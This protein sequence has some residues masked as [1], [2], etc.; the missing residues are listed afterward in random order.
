MPK[1]YIKIP[2]SVRFVDAKTR[3]PFGKTPDEI[4]KNTVSFED[5]VLKVMDNPKWNKSY[6]A[7]KSADAI[8]MALREALDGDGVMV[9]ADSDY[10]EMKTAVESPEIIVYGPTGE[11]RVSP[12][13]GIHPRLS[14]Q[15][16]PLCDAIINASEED[17]RAEKDAPADEAKP[18]A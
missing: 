16:I 4:A 7:I 11:P 1:I 14:P 2:E 12:G 18:E 5:L 13:F 17:P 6:K 15:L 3:E 10:Q 8:M 9:L